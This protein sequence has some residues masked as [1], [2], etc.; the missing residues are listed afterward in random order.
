ME[1]PVKKQGLPKNLNEYRHII[2]G[3][4]TAE[5]TITWTVG[6]RRNHVSPK[7]CSPNGPPS[8]KRPDFEKRPLT[9]SLAQSIVDQPRMRRAS[10][11][12]IVKTA[13]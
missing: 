1:T 3:G 12:E 10:I 9:Q 8:F 7:I 11:Q 5:D 4:V 6:L 13:N 2:D